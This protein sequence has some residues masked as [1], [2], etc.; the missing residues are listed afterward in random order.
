MFCG[1]RRASRPQVRLRA[2]DLLKSVVLTPVEKQAHRARRTSRCSI[3]RAESDN[4]LHDPFI[5]DGG[6]FPPCLCRW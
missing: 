6:A 5:E 2:R 4:G 1:T 3:G